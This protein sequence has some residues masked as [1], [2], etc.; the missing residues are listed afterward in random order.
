MLLNIP[1]FEIEKSLEKL[2]LQLNIYK[3]EEFWK[4]LPN[5]KVDTTI[6]QT[7]TFYSETVEPF[8]TLFPKTDPYPFCCPLMFNSYKLIMEF[9]T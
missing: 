6:S 4:T 8:V 3:A 7:V 5:T 1:L 2:K 9:T